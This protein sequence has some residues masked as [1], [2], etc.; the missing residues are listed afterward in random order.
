MAKR[1]KR[2]NWSGNEKRMI[3]DRTRV[4]DVLVSHVERMYDVNANQVFNWLKEAPFADA[5]PPEAGIAFLPVKI[6][7]P[8]DMPVLSD[9][10]HPGT[11]EIDLCSGHR[12][13]I[14]GTYR[15]ILGRLK[16]QEFQQVRVPP[17]TLFAC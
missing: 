7:K 5:E 9:S 6:T 14:T 8:R 10:A 2:R 11:P 17:D 13:R 4:R 1:G 15:V 16:L 3:C 12:L